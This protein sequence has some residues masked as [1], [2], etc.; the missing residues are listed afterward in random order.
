[1][2]LSRIFSVQNYQLRGKIV[3][4]EADVT[5]GLHNFKIIGMADK[6]IEEAKDRISTALKHT[7]YTSP[8]HKNQKVV[9]SLAPAEVRKQ[10]S[11]FDVPIALSYLLAINEVSFET[12]RK[13]FIGELALNGE[14]QKVSGIIPLLIA[15]KHHGFQEIY[16][17]SENKDEGLF[18]ADEINIYCVEN[19]NKLINHL[20]EKQS[21]E[22]LKSKKPNQNTP[23]TPLYYLNSIKGNY[24][25]KRAL[26]IAAAGRHN[27]ALYGSPGTGKTMLAKTC[28]SLLPPL[29]QEEQLQK[30][31]MESLTEEAPDLTTT[32]P[33]RSPHHNTSATALLG[34][35]NPIKP[36][37]IARA[38]NGILFLDEFPEF[39]SRSIEGLREPLEEK[40]VTIARS[41]EC[42]RYPTDCMCIIA[43]N[44]CPCGYLHHTQKECVCTQAGIDRYV[45][46]LSGPIVDRIEL[47]V[48]VE[49]VEYAELLISHQKTQDTTQEEAHKKI[50]Q[51]RTLQK[52][53]NTFTSNSYLNSNIS[54]EDIIHHWSISSGVVSILEEFARKTSL[55]ARG[56]YAILRIAR[57]ISDLEG[58]KEISKK[59]LLEALQYRKK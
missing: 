37:E 17:P 39:G 34:G 26:L 8:K 3:Q 25:A 54:S 9:I 48:P 59:S 4:I 51:A 55:S 50:L 47:W 42:V 18:L 38:H 11:L 53:R 5:N 24:F 28:Q 36:G 35:G 45:K 6:S 52:G 13:I 41:R 31:V 57:T 23:Q 58:E 46:K 29:S 49:E 32:P 21:L 12:E 30:A 10:G 1:M 33:F 14:I 22:P 20:E 40:S 56:Y 19:L 7:G 27:I 43:Y 2:K 15:A 16:I 44:P